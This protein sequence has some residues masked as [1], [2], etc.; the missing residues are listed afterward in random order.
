MF[1]RMLKGKADVVPKVIL[2]NVV[3][4]KW[5]YPKEVLGFRLLYLK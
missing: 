3:V 5:R 2:Y 4:F 1:I